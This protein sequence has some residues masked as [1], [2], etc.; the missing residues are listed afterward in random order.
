MKNSYPAVVMAMLAVAFYA[1]VAI[2]AQTNIPRVEL[3]PNMPAPYQMRDWKQVARDYDNYVFSFT[4]TTSSSD[5]WWQTYPIVWWDREHRNFSWDTFGMPS[6]I[7][8]PTMSSGG[9]HEAINCLGAVLGGS[10]AGINKSN[11]FVAATGLY[12][13]F[14]LME[15]QYYNKTNGENMVLNYT[16]TQSGQSFWYEVF[17]PLLFCQLLAKYPNTGSMETL[18]SSMA[19]RLYNAEVVMGGKTSPWTVPNFTHTA[20]NFDTNQPFDNSDWKEP[21]AAAGYAWLEYMAYVKWGA[22]QHITGADWG[23]QYLLNRTQNP[24]YEVLLPYGAYTAARM[25]AEQGRS[26]DVTKLINWCFEPSTAS[27]AR[28][29][30]GVIADSPWGGYDCD[31]LVGSATDGD[32]YAFAM[33]TFQW[34]TA[35]TPIPRYNQDY[36]RAIGKWMLNAANASRLFYTNGLDAAHQSSESWSYIYD[37]CNCISYEGLRKTPRI[38]DKAVS[39]YSNTYGTVTGT[40]ANTQVKDSKYEVLKE[41]TVGQYDKLDHVWQLNITASG[42]HTLHF[43]GHY[44]DAGDDDTGFIIAYATSPEGAYTDM[45]TVSNTGG[46]QD[47][48]YSLPSELSGPIYIKARDTNPNTPGTANDKLY[49]N[50]MM[51]I[52]E[53]TAFAP[54]AMGD[55]LMWG[56]GT[57]FALYGASHVGMLATVVNT[58]NVEEILQLDL[59][60]TDYYHAT[61]YPTY[62]YYNPY[63]TPQTVDVNVGSV[64]TDVYDTVSQEIVKINASGIVE[65]NIPA[66]SAMVLVFAPAGGQVTIDGTKKLINGVVVDYKTNTAYL[67]CAQVQAS[68]QRLAG[69]INGDCM[70]D[71]Y[72]LSML[73]QSWLLAGTSLGRA[74]I[75]D[76]NSI[77][78]LDFSVLAGQWLMSNV[79]ADVQI[80]SFDNFAANGWVDGYNTRLMMQATDPNFVHEGTGSLR[81]KYEAMA[82]TQWDVKP[83]HVFSPELNMAGAT[84]SFWLWTDLVNDSKLNQVIVYDYANRLARFSV[85]RPTSVGW[86]KITTPQSA[87]IPDASPLDYNRIK[88][89]EFWF[90]T[91][92]TP[93]NSVYLDDLWMAAGNP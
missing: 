92:D 58:T 75:N 34:A 41:Q 76:D 26:Y 57:D 12:Y 24:L 50:W 45:F 63:G 80:E 69:D 87:F 71:I 79:L 81:V 93:G 65:V 67:N 61:A 4:R 33:N 35:L 6:Y 72:D 86:T 54:Y 59:L 10:L 82:P 89:M 22:S 74:N 83:S 28:Y 13:N 48:T 78:L 68:P 77:N 70:V 36:A 23:I 3:M 62:L 85:P 44:V 9:A 43:Y 2:A 47:Y 38:V 88:Q 56:M 8:H 25:N 49:V 20:F 14:V 37:P 29:G 17:P 1:G 90:S 55:G 11:Q 27:D 91:W 21:D 46:D 52:T 39:D 42:S 66:D 40:Y 60:A 84:L 30:W 31:G 15:Q 73:V 19:D 51:V 5:S 18:M 16:S 32:G 7:G 53:T 64:P